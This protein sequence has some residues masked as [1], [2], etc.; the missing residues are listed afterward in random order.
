MISMKLFA[1]FLERN[2]DVEEIE[3]AC[4]YMKKYILF[5]SL[6]IHNMPIIYEFYRI[7]SDLKNLQQQQIY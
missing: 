3:K 2:R 5:K 7:C 6:D 1:V 4:V